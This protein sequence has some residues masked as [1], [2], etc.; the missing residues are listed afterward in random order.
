MPSI[1]NAIRK[2]FFGDKDPEEVLDSGVGKTAKE[3][4]T[5]KETKTGKSSGVAP[6]GAAG[7]VYH[8]NATHLKM[9]GG[10]DVDVIPSNKGALLQVSGSDG[11]FTISMDKEEYG[12]F[13]CLDQ[14]QKKFVESFLQQYAPNKF[15]ELNGSRLAGNYWSGPDKKFYVPVTVAELDRLN[16]LG[17]QERQQYFRELLKEKDPQQYNALVN[18]EKSLVA[19]KKI[20]DAAQTPWQ[21]N[22]SPTNS[23]GNQGTAA[24]QNK[25]KQYP[26]EPLNPRISKVTPFVDENTVYLNMTVDGKEKNLTVSNRNTVDAF[27]AGALPLNVLANKVLEMT[28][29][30]QVNLQNRFEM[31]LEEQRS[32]EQSQLQGFH[33]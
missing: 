26:D 1:F 2:V 22:G 33:R 27:N 13:K 25:F 23:I 32:Q 4:L 14:G 17:K 15:K 20:R 30:L 5:G 7:E 8:D 19:D 9:F 31:T 3:I 16:S 24:W 28:D 18:A 29:R 11:V 12:K 10:R 6:A 21:R